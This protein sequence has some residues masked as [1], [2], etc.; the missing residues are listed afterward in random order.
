MGVVVDLSWDFACKEDDAP[1]LHICVMA[2]VLP[3][4]VVIEG[5]DFTSPKENLKAI[6][7]Y[8]ET[9][10]ESQSRSHE[11]LSPW[12]SLD[13]LSDKLLDYWMSFLYEWL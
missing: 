11:V 13:A 5:L 3:L 8:D 9:S 1:V 10:S 4:S 6:E 2:Q 7:P 12:V